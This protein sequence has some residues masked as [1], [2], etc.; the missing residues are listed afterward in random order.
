MGPTIDSYPSYP[1][2]AARIVLLTAGILFLVGA[3]TALAQQYPV[4]PVRL[5]VPY[6]PGGGLDIFARIFVPPL[7]QAIGQ[8]FVIDNRPGA[9]SII[10]TNLAAK[11]APD[12]YTLLLI[13]PSH[14]NNPS[15]FD[16]LPYS[17]ERDFAPVSLIALTSFVLVVHPSLPVHSLGELIAFARQKPGQLSYAS[18]GNASTSHLAVEL[19]KAMANINM[20]HVPFKGSAQAITSVL[21]G[22]IPMFIGNFLN[23][24]PHVRFGKFRALGVTS[25]IRTAELPD[26][27]TFAEAGLAGYEAEGFYGFVAPAGTP[28]A[29]ISLLSAETAKVVQALEM[30][31]RFSGEGVTLI[32]SK[33]AALASFIRDEIAKWAKIIR[34]SGAKVD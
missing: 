34:L 8:Q 12:G 20:V 24:M 13:A 28:E 11:S 33:P 23:V 5:I 25:R 4:K 17:T 16:K 15:L 19:L 6:P 1:R 7:S 2:I 31:K 21:S 30:A 32:G 18:S 29:I 14:V 9:S 10:G 27:P 26:M 3:P 22:E